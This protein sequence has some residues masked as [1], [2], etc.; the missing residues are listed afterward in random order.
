[1]LSFRG[2]RGGD[3]RVLG[4]AAAELSGA[5]TAAGGYVSSE[6]VENDRFGA[7]LRRRGG[8]AVYDVRRARRTVFRR[9]VN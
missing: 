3:S 9:G 6:S 7:W 8:N 1:M 4:K 5:V 2:L